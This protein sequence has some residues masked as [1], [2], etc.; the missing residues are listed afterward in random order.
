[1]VTRGVCLACNRSRHQLNQNGHTDVV[2]STVNMLHVLRELGPQLC[3][4]FGQERT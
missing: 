4:A 1:M 2:V 3:V